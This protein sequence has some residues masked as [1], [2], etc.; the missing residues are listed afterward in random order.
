MT[1]HLYQTLIRPRRRAMDDRDPAF[2]LSAAT[3]WHG[4]LA[5][6]GDYEELEPAAGM[7][8]IPT[9]S[10]R[11]MR[12]MLA[13]IARTLNEQGWTVNVPGLC[14]WWLAKM[15]FGVVPAYYEAIVGDDSGEGEY[16]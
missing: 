2:T 12:S 4:I 10:E 1:K 11:T 8:L 3:Y 9:A 6:Y 5:L 15:E 7:W 14:N 13:Q 16:V